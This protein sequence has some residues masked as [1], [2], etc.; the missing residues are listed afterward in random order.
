M[1][2]IK[3]TN[4]TKFS[5]DGKAIAEIFVDGKLEKVLIASVSRE[6]D[7]NFPVPKLEEQS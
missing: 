1:I 3:I 4:P 7:V 6:L 2:E 5:F